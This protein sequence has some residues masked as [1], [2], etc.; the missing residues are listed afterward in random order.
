MKNIIKDGDDKDM[1]QYNVI[2]IQYIDDNG[3]KK[4]YQPKGYL[5][6][7]PKEKRWMGR[8]RKID[9]REKCVY[10]RTK[11]E[12]KELLDL[13]IEK[14]CRDLNLLIKQAGNQKSALIASAEKGISKT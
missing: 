3:S 7:R 2:A 14:Y 1:M 12:C 8:F 9:R 10:A 5:S 4:V 11:R 13:E 6:Y